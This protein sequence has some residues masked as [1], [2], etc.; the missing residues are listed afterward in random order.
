VISCQNFFQIFIGFAVFSNGSF[1]LLVKD[2]PSAFRQ[3]PAEA[4]FVGEKHQQKHTTSK[5]L[6]F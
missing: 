4:S 5:G 6:I 2:L 1:H 3:A